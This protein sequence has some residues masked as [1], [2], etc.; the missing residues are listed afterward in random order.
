MRAVLVGFRDFLRQEEAEDILYVKNNEA[1]AKGSSLM[2]KKISELSDASSLNGTELIPI[3]QTSATVKTAIRPLRPYDAVIDGRTDAQAGTALLNAIERLN[4]ANQGG[5]VHVM[6]GAINLGTNTLVLS[7]GVVVSGVTSGHRISHTNSKGTRLYWTGPTNENN[8]VKLTGHGARLSNLSVYVP[9]TLTGDSVLIDGGVAGI[10]KPAIQHVKITGGP[11][12]M[13]Y[14]GLVI[15][16]SYSV[17]VRDV[18]L[19]VTANGIL[20][21]GNLNP[22]NTGNNSFSD[23][24]VFQNF[25]NTIGIKIASPSLTQRTNLMTFTQCGA[26]TRPGIGAGCTG[27]MLRGASRLN[28]IGLDLENHEVLLDIGVGG[29]NGPASHN[30]F[31]GPYLNSSTYG[32]KN[33]VCDAASVNNTFIGGLIA[34]PAA[35]SSELQYDLTKGGADP[36]HYYH[37]RKSTGGYF[38]EA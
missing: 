4:A 8:C 30:V 22:Y 27:L 24:F 25:N 20:I 16:D 36:N 13:T 38:T 35:Q 15:R 26:L 18:M 23:L 2:S 10:H 14:W 31:T 17:A 5:E 12:S 21:D 7:E 34:V 3:V 1:S 9:T 11:I 6:A 32:L 29:G 37:V 19:E 28:F 33:V